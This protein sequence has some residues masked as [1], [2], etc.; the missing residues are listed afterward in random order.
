V[1][2]DGLRITPN[3]C[4]TLEKVDTFASTMARILERRLP[5]KG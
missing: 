2:V 4:T 5:A 3:V 1:A